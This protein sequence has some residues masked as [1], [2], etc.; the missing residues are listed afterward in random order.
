M[1]I[2]FAI[3]SS[4]PYIIHPD[5]DGHFRFTHNTTFKMS[6]VGT[7]FKSPHRLS[8]LVNE[9]SVKC[10]NGFLMYNGRPYVIDRFKCNKTPRSKLVITNVTCQGNKENR[11]VKVGFYST[12]G[13][14][15]VYKICYNN[16]H[17]Y[18]LYSWMFMKSPFY[19]FRQMSEQYA[20]YIHTGNYG[21]TSVTM[22]YGNQVS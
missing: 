20:R 13:F 14:I 19:K 8:S 18:A 9:I 4:T 5:Q 21:R 7:Y 6:C 12:F 22:S 15:S 17:K 11:V 16:V 10:L 3:N 1:P 2:P